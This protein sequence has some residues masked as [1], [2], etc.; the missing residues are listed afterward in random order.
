MVKILVVASCNRNL[1]MLQPDGSLGLY[2][3]RTFTFNRIS[4]LRRHE[5]DV[6]PF[7]FVAVA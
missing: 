6:F 4:C 3:D 7:R 1:D 5:N 2:A